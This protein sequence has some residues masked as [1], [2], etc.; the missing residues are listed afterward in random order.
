M[1]KMQEQM[2]RILDAKN[3]QHIALGS[4]RSVQ[5]CMG[6]ISATTARRCSSGA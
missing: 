1:L 6:S 3:P 5:T 2:H 4:I